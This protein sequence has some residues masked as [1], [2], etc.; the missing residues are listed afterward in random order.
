[1]HLYSSWRKLKNCIVKMIPQSANK[2]NKDIFFCP[3]C[4]VWVDKDRKLRLMC[5]GKAAPSITSP[6][7]HPLSTYCA[8][9][10]PPRCWLT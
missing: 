9:L 3:L 2:A 6:C 10:E 7:P 4:T 5:I 1:M 8:S